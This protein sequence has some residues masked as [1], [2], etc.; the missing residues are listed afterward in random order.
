[1]IRAQG[2]G[3]LRRLRD[4]HSM[5]LELLGEKEEKLMELEDQLH[6]QHK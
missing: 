3:E 2:L 4:E 1:M 5:V 6:S